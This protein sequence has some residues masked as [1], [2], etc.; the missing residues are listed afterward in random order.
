MNCTSTNP[1]MYEEGVPWDCMSCKYQKHIKYQEGRIRYLELELKAAR[2]EIDSL[3]NR[4]MS[5]KIG[6]KV[7]ANDIWLKTKN[8]KSRA[9]RFSAD[10]VSQISLSNKFSLLEV[11]H[12]QGLLKHKD[13]KIRSPTVKSKTQGKKKR[14]CYLEVVMG[15]ILDPCYNH[16]WVLNMK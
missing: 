8:S 10:D 3:K 16:T 7:N 11:D 6:D 13:M 12:N 9:H 15:G 4:N 1:N 14:Y 2:D 5:N